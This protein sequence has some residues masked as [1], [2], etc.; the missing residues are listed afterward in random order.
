[1]NGRTNTSL[2]PILKQALARLALCLLPAALSFGAMSLAYAM[3]LLAECSYNWKAPIPCIFLGHD[4]GSL[5][6]A[7]LAYGQIGFIFGAVFFAWVLVV[8]VITFCWG[9]V[10]GSQKRT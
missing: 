3:S 9:Y 4:I 5:V 7:L 1:M 2:K 10:R 8:F 6:S